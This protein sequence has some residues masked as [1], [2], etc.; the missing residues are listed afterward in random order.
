MDISDKLLKT[1]IQI[2]SHT[3]AGIVTGTGFFFNF[4]FNSQTQECVPAIVTN[5]H[6]IK[7]A[8][9]GTLKFTISN[10][11][12]HGTDKCT[13]TCN[14][15]DFEKQ[16]ILH[17]EEKVDLAIYLL[18]PIIRDADSK[19]IKL[20]FVALTKNDIITPEMLKNEVFGIE[21][22]TIV[23]YPDGIWDDINNI[24]IVREG[25]TATPLQIDFKNEANF[26]VDAAIYGGS[27]GSPVYL[28]NNGAFATKDS[29]NMGSRIK[30]VGI[31]A[32]V[33]QHSITGGIQIVPIPTAFQTQIISQIPNN[34]GVAIHA[35][36]L[37]DFE[38]ILQEEFLRQ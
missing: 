27:S 22:V 37:L 23:G 20:E 33:Y 14:I 19:K 16:C 36:K 3:A 21:N 13:F 11:E 1:T 2:T 18:A 32:Q 38:K 7:N 24:P 9:K 8:L 10:Q 6:V 25:I 17:P 26:L 15:I 28:F 35:R 31:I 12:S 5:K 29:L 30:L 4:C 34:L